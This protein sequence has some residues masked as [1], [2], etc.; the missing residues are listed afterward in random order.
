[1]SGDDIV[2]EYDLNNICPEIDNELN[3]WF[4]DLIGDDFELGI[5]PKPSPD[6]ENAVVVT[7]EIMAED[8]EL[9]S[10]QVAAIRKAVE[11]RLARNLGDQWEALKPNFGGVQVFFNDELQA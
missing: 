10:E 11:E 2:S 7:A 6:D 5:F 8:A 4:V 3:W 1:M 9:N